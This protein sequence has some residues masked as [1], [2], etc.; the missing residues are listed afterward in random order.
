MTI[1]TTVESAVPTSAARAP[2]WPVLGDHSTV[3]RIFVPRPVI[4][5][6]ES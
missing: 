4:A 5:G 3:V 6:Q 2:Y 1:A